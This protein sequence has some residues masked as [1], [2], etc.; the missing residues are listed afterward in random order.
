MNEIEP[1]ALYVVA[2][3]IGNRADFSPRAQQVLS[4]V[5]GIAAE[6]T[7]VS[8]PLLRDAGIDTPLV[9]LHEH[10]ETARVPALIARLQKGE[11]LALI[12]DAGTPLISDPGFELVRAARAADLKVLTVPGPCAAI[13][14]LS[15]A[16]LPSDR[17]QFSGFVLPKSAARVRQFE[18]VAGVA[19]T[20]IFY[21]SK[22]VLGDA[23]ADAAKVFGGERPAVICR[24]LTKL[25]EQVHTGSL[26][27]LAACWSELE[28]RGEWVLLIGG[29]PASVP[30]AEDL[31]RTL[32][33]L[34]E[35]LSVRDAAAIAGKL[36]GM[37]KR[38]AYAAALELSEK[39]S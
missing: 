19:A 23:L 39:S 16:G 31:R 11:S 28:H 9:S 7:R 17:F 22:R 32:G 2:T 13:A 18:T 21:A 25:H 6:D 33:V 26:A 10:N 35:K 1:R 5:D 37:P 38:D 30:G 36:L 24:E 3:P 14:A 8:G 27:E 12:S 4:D 20:L 34:L 29:V 15:I